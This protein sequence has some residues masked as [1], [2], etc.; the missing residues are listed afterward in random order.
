VL[1]DWPGRGQGARLTFEITAG[2][3]VDLGVTDVRFDIGH[4]ED[5][6]RGL[7]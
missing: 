3:R 7:K 4:N 1:A 2:N 6:S 5:Y